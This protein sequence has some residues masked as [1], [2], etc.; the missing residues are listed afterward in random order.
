MRR[1]TIVSASVVACCVA[2][3]PPMFPAW[4]FSR[5]LGGRGSETGEDQLMPLAAASQV[6]VRERSVMVAACGSDRVVVATLKGVPIRAVEDLPCPRGV[7]FE[8]ESGRV[9]VAT[10]TGITV[11]DAD[12]RKLAEFGEV[13][14]DRPDQMGAPAKLAV[15]RGRLYVAD[16]HNHRVL[17]FDVRDH[18]SPRHLF[19]IGDVGRREGEFYK[20][21]GVAV[22]RDRLFVADTHNHR[23]QIVDANDGRHI[24]T[25]KAV[26]R[27][28]TDA[29]IAGCL[30]YVA[31][32]A[33]VQVFTLA[34]DRLADFD[35]GARVHFAGLQGL[36]VGADGTLYVANAY[37]DAVPIFKLDFR[38][39]FKRYQQDVCIPTAAVASK[40]SEPTSRR[41][42]S[43][44]RLAQ[45]VA[46]GGLCFIVVRCATDCRR[47]AAAAEDDV[48]GGRPL[49]MTTTVVEAS[50]PPSSSAEPPGVT[51]RS[52]AKRGDVVR[53]DVVI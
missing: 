34:G 40:V 46:L 17:V 33:T 49:P 37:D 18:T 50:S 29:Y 16:S 53:M 47:V 48:V 35:G 24:A 2:T 19:S 31:D 12:L 20:P 15:W 1:L 36:A 44:A 9:F 13:G 43:L 25:L 5:Y 7:A 4:V 27:R 23:V 10:S 21:H 11:L 28:P 26:F 14:D 32:L 6:A 42:L 39:D 38:A 52:V 8:P 41:R 22:A 3:T 51:K 30:L 45:F